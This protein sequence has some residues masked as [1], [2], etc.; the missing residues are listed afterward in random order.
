MKQNLFNDEIEKF[1]GD[2]NLRVY[3]LFGVIAVAFVFLG[4]ALST[5]TGVAGVM[6][7]MV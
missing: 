5:L 3:I 2:S 7:E 1:T 6:I 4:W